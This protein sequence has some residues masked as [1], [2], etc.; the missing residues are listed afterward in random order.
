[1]KIKKC[2]SIER[3]KY[4][5]KNEKSKIEIKIKTKMLQQK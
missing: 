3:K 4:E 2:K 1:M 5:N